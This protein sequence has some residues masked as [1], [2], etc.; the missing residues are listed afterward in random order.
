MRFPSTVLL[1]SLALPLRGNAVEPPATQPAADVP[2]VLM[3]L[4]HF[5]WTASGPLV[6]P[7]DPPGDRHYSVK[8]PSIVRYGGRW[9]L[10]TSVRGVKR[11]HA[12][13]YFTFADWKDAPKAERHLLPG[14]DGYWC[15]PQVFY[16]APQKTWYLICQASGEDWQPTKYGPAFST[17]RDIADWRGWSAPQRLDC[18]KTPTDKV[19]LDFWVICD[20]ARAYLF[21]TSL[22]GRMWRSQTALADFP[23]KWSVPALALQADIFEAS[24]TYCLAG[25]AKYMT[26]VEAQGGHGWRYYKAFLADRLDG[27]WTPL[28]AGRDDAFASMKSVTQ[29][30]GRWTDSISHIE[31]IRAGFDQQMDVDPAHLQVVFQGVSDK[32]RAG[33]KYGE[34]PWRLGI[35]TATT[36]PDG[37]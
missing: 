24:H 8:D 27:K 10:F 17:N 23:H 12:I 29:P 31:L 13:E 36:Q 28:A 3:P 9:H 25:M 5:Q 19:G 6:A 22:D 14:Y 16:F 30:G 18:P 21:F 15:A 7:A 4:G 1:L 26:V 34:I 37:Q 32:D 11:S 33:K 2:A 35:L 20:D